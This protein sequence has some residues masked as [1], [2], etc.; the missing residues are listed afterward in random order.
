MLYSSLIGTLLATKIPGIIYVSQDMK[1][2]R[3]VYV[4]EEIEVVVEVLGPLDRK[5]LFWNF[6][7]TVN[8]GEDKVVVL[9]G[10]A[11]S[12]VPAAP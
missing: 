7:T 9:E 10:K 6:D 11:V 1:F 8:K 4:G 3:P 2:K 12:K 5:N